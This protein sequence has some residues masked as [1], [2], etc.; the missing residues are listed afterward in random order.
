MFATHY[1]FISGNLSIV[2]GQRLYSIVWYAILPTLIIDGVV[3]SS[4]S[5]VVLI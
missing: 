1:N 5:F 3:K 2:Y 4:I